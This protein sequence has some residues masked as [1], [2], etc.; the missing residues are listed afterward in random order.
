MRKI[1][2]EARRRRQRHRPHRHVRATTRGGL[3]LLPGL[4]VVERALRRWLRVPRPAAADHR[5]RRGRDPERRRPQ[6][7]LAHQLLLHGHRHHTG[8][9]HAP[10][11]HRLAVHLRDARQRRRVP[12]RRPQL[13]PHA[14]ARHPREPV[15]V[16]DALRPPDPLHAP[17]RSAP[18]A[19]SA[20]S[21]A[22]SRR[23]PTARPTST[24]GP[25]LP[26]ARRT[27]G[28][29]PFPARAGGRSFG[30]TT[31]SSRSSTRPGGRARS[32]SWTRQR[33]TLLVPETNVD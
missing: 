6:A 33:P 13:S 1:L 29:R 2:E 26:T 32:R 18:A 9:V 10:H 12:R 24:S 31:R 19:T 15:L 8:D 4:G 21:P 25:Q 5:R 28:S 11:R 30:S 16:G 20:A 27:T 7:Q 17:D 3:R 22:P 14:P 23:T